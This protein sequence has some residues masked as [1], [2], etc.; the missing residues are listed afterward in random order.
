MNLVMF[1][2]VMCPKCAVISK[3]LRDQG[4]TF[5][6]VDAEKQQKLVENFQIMS[7]P[8]TI[9]LADDETEIA[10]TTGVNPVEL[11]ELIHRLREGEMSNV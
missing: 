11:M 10:R 6:V 2:T 4:V 9:L 3:F 8:T 1:K 7:V 5:A